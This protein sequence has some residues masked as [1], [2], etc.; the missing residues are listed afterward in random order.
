[1]LNILGE[2]QCLGK[3]AEGD[4][5]GLDSLQGICSEG[6]GGTTPENARTP[7]RRGIP[8]YPISS[9]VMTIDVSQAQPR[10][11]GSSFSRLVTASVS[12]RVQRGD[13]DGGEQGGDT[14]QERFDRAGRR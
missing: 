7:P 8:T 11:P 3:G 14:V 5:A 13:G 6:Q 4:F 12:G 2:I 10:G 1:V 9:P